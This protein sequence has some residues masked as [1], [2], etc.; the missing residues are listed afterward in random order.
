MFKAVSFS[1]LNADCPFCSSLSTSIACS[2]SDVSVD[3][4]ERE[5]KE[6]HMEQGNWKRVE[7]VAICRVN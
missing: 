2:P 5:G 7:R 6:E 1:L 4:G 3:R